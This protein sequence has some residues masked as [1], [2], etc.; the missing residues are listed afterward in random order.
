MITAAHGRAGSGGAGSL[1]SRVHG[2]SAFRSA[3]RKA[4]G[5]DAPACPAWR[6]ERMGP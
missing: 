3:P 6:N 2:P 5:V 1:P 4:R